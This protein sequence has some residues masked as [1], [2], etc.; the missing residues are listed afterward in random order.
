MPSDNEIIEGIISHDRKVLNY[1]YKELLPYV[2]AFVV[3]HGGSSDNARDIFQEGMIIIYRKIESG[4]FTL[5]CKFSTYLYA[6]C[7]RLWIQERKKYLHRLE[8]VKEIN[9]VA[10]SPAVYETEPDAAQE[11]FQ[12]HFS[13]LSPE[14][15]QILRMYFNGVPL[16]EIRKALEINTVHHA[17]DKKYRCKKNLIDRIRK[18]PLFIKMKK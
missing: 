5:Q 11:L 4:N 9:V 18:D 8:K 2:D 17:S 12:K 7:K 14:C 16:E 6:V 1:V 3:H 15:Q 13:K 10:E